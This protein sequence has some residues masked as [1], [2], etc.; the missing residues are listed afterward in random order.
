MNICLDCNTEFEPDKYHPNQKYCKECLIRR[1]HESIRR[2]RKDKGKEYMRKYM[3]YYRTLFL[4]YSFPLFFLHLL[5]FYPSICYSDIFE[6]YKNFKNSYFKDYSFLLNLSGTYV[7][8]PPYH[9]YLNINS[10]YIDLSRFSISR[11]GWTSYSEDEVSEFGNISVEFGNTTATYESSLIDADSTYGWLLKLGDT[12][13]ISFAKSSQN[14]R[15]ALLGVNSDY[16]N[17]TLL[18]SFGKLEEIDYPFEETQKIVSYPITKREGGSIK[19]PIR[20]KSLSGTFEFSAMKRYDEI[21]LKNTSG[22]AFLSNLSSNR[23]NLSLTNFSEGFQSN[24]RTTDFFLDYYLYKTQ[25]TSLSSGFRIIDYSGSQDSRYSFTTGFIKR[26][27]NFSIDS[28]VYLYKQ[29]ENKSLTATGNISF[30]LL[31]SNFSFTR[32]ETYTGY[33]IVSSNSLNTSNKYFSLSLNYSKSE[34]LNTTS[35]NYSLSFRT[36]PFRH[37]TF[38]SS[39]NKNIYETTD[40]IRTTLSSNYSIT[41]KNTNLYMSFSPTYESYTFSRILTKKLPSVSLG[42]TYQRFIGGDGITGSFTLNF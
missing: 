4:I 14:E 25:S 37:F 20:F 35:N 11:K 6:S 23:L 18:K 2:W 36:S 13:E 26:F 39:V 29:G 17:L 30:K 34:Y 32:T 27:D 9:I 12:V 10:S 16:F 40:L 5:L 38:S 41:F 42:I 22:I 7:K 15:L 24:I 31:Q 28:K 3:K 19:I 21:E 1:K 8:P 33:N